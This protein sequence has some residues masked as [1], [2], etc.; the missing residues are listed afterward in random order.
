MPCDAR[1]LAAQALDVRVGS[2]ASGPDARDLP[3]LCYHN[4]PTD[5]PVEVYPGGRSVAQSIFQIDE[6]SRGLETNVGGAL[7]V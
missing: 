4:T 2:R 1:G 5:K 6:H 3:G 7:V